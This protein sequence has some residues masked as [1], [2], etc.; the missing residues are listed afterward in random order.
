MPESEFIWD[1]FEKLVEKLNY[2][3][4]CSYEICKDCRK[5]HRCIGA[6]TTIPFP[7]MTLVKKTEKTI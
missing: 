3:I 6:R 2:C 7:D 1:W 5:K 4:K